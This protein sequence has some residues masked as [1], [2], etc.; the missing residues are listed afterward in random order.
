MLVLCGFVH[1][2][3]ACMTRSVSDSDMN[4][5]ED[6]MFADRVGGET[7][8]VGLTGE[9][10]G[11]LR[12]LVQECVAKIPKNSRHALS[13]FFMENLHNLGTEY[14]IDEFNQYHSQCIPYI[15]K[16]D[17]LYLKIIR[18]VVNTKTQIK[19]IEINFLYYLI[20]TFL[21]KNAQYRFGYSHEERYGFM[22]KA[23]SSVG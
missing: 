15:S 1:T 3:E 2:T 9:T 23:F 20:A 19:F 22:V 11:P 5:H 10:D 13:P 17:M 7:L 21:E 14:D 8:I 12:Q 18:K 16:E 6:L 4:K